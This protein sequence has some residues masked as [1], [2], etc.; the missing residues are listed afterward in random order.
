METR[1]K[2]A[3][4]FFGDTLVVVQALK[5]NLWNFLEQVKIE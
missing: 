2:E 4:I 1:T 3:E 5:F